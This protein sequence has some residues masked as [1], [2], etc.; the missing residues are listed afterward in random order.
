M[1]AIHAAYSSREAAHS[2]LEAQPMAYVLRCAGIVRSTVW[3][4]GRDVADV[5]FLEYHFLNI[6]SLGIVPG[7]SCR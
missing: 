7:T 2:M 5:I 4:F 1:H 3:R 6:V